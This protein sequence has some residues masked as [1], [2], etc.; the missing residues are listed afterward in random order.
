MRNA[1]ILKKKLKKGEV[2]LGTWSIMPSASTLNVIASSGLDFVIIDMEHGPMNF[3]TVEQMVVVSESENCTPL[4][5]VAARDEKLILKALDIGAH[6]VVVPHISQVKDAKESISFIKYSPEGI[7]G[8]SPFT[9]AG[10]YSLDNVAEHAQRENKE[11]LSILMIEGMN[12][13]K[14]L[15]RIIETPG[16]DV[17][18]VGAYDLSQ[19]LGLPGQVDHPRVREELAGCIKKIRARGIASGGYV[20]KNAEDIR[21]M[22]DMGMQFITYLVDTTV[23]Y[24]AFNDICLK[25]RGIKDEGC[26]DNT[27]KAK[28]NSISK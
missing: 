24:H 5:R 26:R 18:Y 22:C 8:F 11:T 10:G 9:W 4:V 2:V 25:F 15:D 21:W 13:I 1:N 7:R 6:G 23:L 28:V 20:A 17:V 3:E 27:S 14:N 19:S 12:G 16:I